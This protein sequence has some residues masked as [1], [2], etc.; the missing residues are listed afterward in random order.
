MDGKTG[1]GA[2]INRCRISFFKVS[3]DFELPEPG[4]Y[5]VSN[6]FFPRKAN[7]RDFVPS[8]SKKIL[9]NKDCDY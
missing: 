1:D 9:K 3:V 6:V 2:G 8:F 7:Q 4:E 5:A